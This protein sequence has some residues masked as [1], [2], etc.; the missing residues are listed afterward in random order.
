MLY[1]ITISLK[2]AVQIYALQHELS[3][4]YSSGKHVPM[5]KY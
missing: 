3:F 5:I 2:E 1:R 4:F